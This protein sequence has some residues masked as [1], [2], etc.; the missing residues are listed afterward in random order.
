MGW[1]GSVYAG[2]ARIPL[3]TGNIR[4]IKLIEFLP[5]RHDY[6]R[7]ADHNTVKRYC[8][9]SLDCGTIGS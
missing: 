1:T 3:Q 9:R 5:L 8:L 6:V 7:Q 2:L 4:Q